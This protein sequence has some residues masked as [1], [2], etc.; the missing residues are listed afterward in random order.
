[1]D[2]CKAYHCF[3]T[4][5]FLTLTTYFLLLAK[6]FRNLWF[7]FSTFPAQS[8]EN[9]LVIFNH[10]YTASQFTFNSFSAYGTM[11]FLITFV[12]YALML[13]L[14]LLLLLF[15]FLTL[16]LIIL[17]A[18]QQ[19]RLLGTNRKLNFREWEWL[20]LYLLELFGVHFLV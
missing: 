3:L 4:S 20:L 17:I 9:L 7:L 6:N 16:S 12:S 11:N 2:C 5:H 13:L 10:S 8:F 15:T 18:K 1:M 14:F 19:G